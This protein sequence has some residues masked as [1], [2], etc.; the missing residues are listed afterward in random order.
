ML[1]VALSVAGCAGYFS[2]WGLSQLFAGA[3]SSVII[4]ATILEIS[5]IVVTTALHKYWSK[6]A[7]GLRI[8]LSFGVIILMFITS[9][10]IYGF[11]SNAYQ[12]TSNKLEIHKSEVN[13]LTN[14]KTFFQKNITDNEKI[15][16]TKNKRADQLTNLRTNQETRLDSAKNN[17]IK[18]KVRNDIA[19][20]TQ[21]IQKLTNDIDVLNTKNSILLDSIGNYDIKILQLESKSDVAS[22]VG[23]LKYISN[24]TGIA[25]DKVVNYLILLLIFVFDP[26]AISLIIATNRIFE[27]NNEN[28]TSTLKELIKKPNLLNIDKHNSE[29]DTPLPKVSELIEEKITDEVKNSNDSEFKHYDQVVSEPFNLISL[30]EESKSDSKPIENV[31]NLTEKEVIQDELPKIE[32]E[33]NISNTLDE[34]KT[35]ENAQEPIITTGKIKLEDI[36]EIK[37]IN[38]TGFSVPIPNPKNKSNIKRV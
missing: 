36:K 18:D 22:E 25:M 32:E 35:D 8:Y 33:L 23:P 28:N 15:I 4:M 12:Q 7:K 5:K 11:L 24:L 16:I 1:L 27:L 21:E 38:R 2:V 34:Q 26:L 14:K 9:T 17:R 13:I 29:E 3:A 20:A 19:I 30:T 6:L 10:G 37:E 31:E